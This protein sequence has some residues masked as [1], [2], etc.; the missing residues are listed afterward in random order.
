MLTVSPWRISFFFLISAL[1]GSMNVACLVSYQIAVGHSVSFMQALAFNRP[2]PSSSC[3]S[4]FLISLDIRLGNETKC[5]PEVP[6][7][8]HTLALNE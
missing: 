8:F 1:I 2:Q 5:H 6:E 3:C 4:K 7:Y